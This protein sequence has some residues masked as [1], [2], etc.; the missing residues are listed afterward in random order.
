[1][2]FPKISMRFIPKSFGY[3]AL[4]VI[5]SKEK[6]FRTRNPFSSFFTLFQ[7]LNFATVEQAIKRFPRFMDFFREIHIM[8]MRHFRTEFA[9]PNFVL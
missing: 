5:K 2:R 7:E 4:F 8:D 1:M 3:F 9:F 6:G